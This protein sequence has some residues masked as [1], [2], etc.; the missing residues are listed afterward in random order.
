MDQWHIVIATRTARDG[1]LQ[2][3]SKPIVEGMASGGFTQT[4]FK[5]DLYIG[6]VDNFD[7]VAKK[8]GLSESFIGDIQRVRC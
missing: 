2:V 4:S 7:H 1:T 3:D 5:T 8:A 6:G